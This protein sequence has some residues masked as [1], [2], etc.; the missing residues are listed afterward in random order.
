MKARGW[1]WGGGEALGQ[2]R[3]L[4]AAVVTCHEEEAVRNL[5]GSWVC[6]SAISLA[7]YI[8][9]YYINVSC[10]CRLF[11]SSTYVFMCCGNLYSPYSRVQILLILA[12]MR[13]SKTRSNKTTSRVQILI[14]PMG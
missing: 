4:Q 1:Q 3:Q 14:Q 9:A 2:G 12:P 5:A 8:T 13:E 6:T 7:A 11:P 10:C